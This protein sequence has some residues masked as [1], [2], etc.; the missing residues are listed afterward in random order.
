LTTVLVDT[1]VVIKWFHATGESE[2]AAAR[3]LRDAHVA[4]R[5]DAHILDLALYEVGNVLVRSLGWRADDVADQLDDLLAILGS[6]LV[7]GS[8]WLRAAAQVAA[9]HRLTFYD[10]AWVAAA[11]GLGVVLVSAD[12]QLLAAGLAESATATVLRLGLDVREEAEDR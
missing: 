10:A 7:C 9:A 4:N 1:S 12:R 6:P 3:A 5:L 8:E 11:R 2:L